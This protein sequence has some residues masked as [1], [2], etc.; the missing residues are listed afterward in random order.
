MSEPMHEPQQP[1]APNQAESPNQAEPQRR[2]AA[3]TP[4]S[5]NGDVPVETWRRDLEQ[6]SSAP[7]TQRHGLL[8]TLLDDLDTQVSSL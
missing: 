3:P 5:V 7:S 6:I 1:A 2:P 8:S 4:A